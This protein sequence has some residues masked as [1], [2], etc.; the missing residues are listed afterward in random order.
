MPVPSRQHSSSE[1]HKDT[2]TPGET[3]QIV[4]Q[5]SRDA[6]TPTEEAALFITEFNIPA[7]MMRN[8][9]D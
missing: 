2:L 5:S 3:Y 6:W 8:T 4:Q 9:W 7:H 1:K